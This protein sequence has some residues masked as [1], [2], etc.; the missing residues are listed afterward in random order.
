MSSI[1][2]V[3]FEKINGLIATLLWSFE[4]RYNVRQ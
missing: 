4:L 2:S 1:L 3:S